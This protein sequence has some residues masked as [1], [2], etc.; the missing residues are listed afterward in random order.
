MIGAFIFGFEQD[1]PTTLD[2][3]Y[4]FA[5]HNRLLL[6]NM[7][8][9]TPF[10]GTDVFEKAQR[11]EKIFDFNWEHYTAANL[12]SEHP[13]MSKEE[14][15]EIQSRFPKRFYSWSSIL[16]RFWANRFHPLYY[17][18]M[19]LAHWWRAHNRKPRGQSL[20]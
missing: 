8:I 12:V 1:T 2:R 20:S 4:D 18:T 5:V 17:L 19:N 3:I 9:M 11:E 6:V 15:E 13:T 14:L 16:K 10:P 7:G